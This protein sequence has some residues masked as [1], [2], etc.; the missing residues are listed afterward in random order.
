MANKLNMLRNV[1]MLMAIGFI[2]L[3]TGLQNNAKAQLGD[4]GQILSSSQEDANTIV[5][6]Y[7]RPFASGFGGGLN[8]GWTNTARTHGVL[9][10][11]LTVGASMAI[12]PSGDRSFNVNELGLQQLELES[13]SAKTPSISGKDN[14]NTTLAAYSEFENPQTGNTREEK[15]FEIPMPPGS[16]F[17][18]VPAPTIKGAVGLPMNSEVMFRYMPTYNIPRTGGKIDLFGIGAK[19]QISQYLPGSK[20]LPVDISIM[21]GYTKLNLSKGFNVTPED[22]ITQPNDTRNPYA[23]QPETWDGQKLDM[24]TTAYT[25]NALVGYTI[26][27]I[28]VVSAYAGVGYEASTMEVSSPGNYPTVE[29][30][31]DYD[32]VAQNE[33]FVVGQVTEPIDISMDGKN[34]FRGIV[35]AQVK[36]AVIALSASYTISEYPS[37]NVGIGISFR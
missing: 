31:P 13:G 30:N 20:L 34:S 27:I 36:V 9:G 16:G 35:G 1:T 14:T 18:Y 2:V 3:G 15:L 23:N 22:I 24:T 37:A 17:E 21:G 8:N 19:H 7:L 29:P 33:K 12:V 28:K 5:K 25:V 4:V 11:D 26:P 10:F 32:P 6:S